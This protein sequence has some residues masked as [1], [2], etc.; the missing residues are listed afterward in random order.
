MKNNI[1]LF[2]G[3][4]IFFWFKFCFRNYGHSAAG[5]I[6]SAYLFLYLTHEIWQSFDNE[7]ELKNT[8]LE[9]SISKYE[10]LI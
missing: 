8:F 6:V 9:L 5:D 2:V 1:Y 3:A 4:R 10:G 7:F